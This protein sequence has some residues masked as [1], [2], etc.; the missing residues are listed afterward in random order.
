[1]EIFEDDTPCAALDGLRPHL[2]VKGSDYGGAPLPEEPAMER[3]AG[4]VVL[5]AVESGR[6][7]S[8]VIQR[9][10]EATA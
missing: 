9:P 7:T 2:F 8:R 3:W 1:V 6:S 10:A 5:L 4:R